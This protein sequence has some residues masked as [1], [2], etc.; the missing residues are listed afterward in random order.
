MIIYMAVN[1]VSFSLEWEKA[2][3][4]KRFLVTA[5]IN[6]IFTLLNLT[7]LAFSHIGVACYGYI[8]W[9]VCLDLQSWGF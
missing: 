9:P 3:E 7:F 1:V 4:W 2:P 5:S 6:Q 8:E